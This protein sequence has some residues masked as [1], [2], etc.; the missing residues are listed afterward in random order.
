MKNVKKMGLRFVSAVMCASLMFGLAACNKQPE[1]T[2]AEFTAPNVAAARTFNGTANIADAKPGDTIVFGKYEQ[3][4]VTSNG[5]E[6]IEW[7]VL[8]NDG[9]KVL[10]IS[11]DVLDWMRFSGSTTVWEYSELREWLNNDFYNSAFTSE[12]Q[13]SIALSVVDNPG[14][15]AFGTA[16]SSGT[17]DNVFLLSFDEAKTYF[18]FNTWDEGTYS[19]YSQ[20]M[21]S[22]ATTWAQGR[23][24]AGCYPVTEEYY[25]LVLSNYGYSNTCLTLSG[26]DWW[27]RTNGSD[28]NY[29]CV[30]GMY[31]SLDA[32]NCV[33]ITYV[34]GVRPAMYLTIG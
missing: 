1:E 5:E 17:N 2:S 27:L 18:A 9:E 23:K 31:G 7:L 21:I 4:N 3:D 28:G 30:A 16:G 32:S 12:E 14:N 13:S 10:V 26:S 8:D 6:Y 34:K 24:L 20:Y 11:K 22:G 19:G 33:D 29:A 15:P 25:N